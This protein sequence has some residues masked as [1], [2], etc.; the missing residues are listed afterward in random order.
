VV[1]SSGDRV[2]LATSKEYA[3]EIL[4]AGRLG[5]QDN[6]RNAVPD[7]DRTTGVLYLNFDSKWR[8]SLISLATEEE[9]GSAA[10]ADANTAPL[11]SLG[12]SAWQDGEVSH[13]L[14]K[15]STD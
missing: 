15:L 5:S 6:F 8:D 3:D 11:R 10:E 2:A 9:A 1:Q 13:A 7:A 4:G 12:I 14:V